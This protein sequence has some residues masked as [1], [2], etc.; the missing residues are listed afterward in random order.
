L[1]LEGTL[2][3]MGLVADIGR[4]QT[5][6]DLLALDAAQIV[7]SGAGLHHG[8]LD[9]RH[10]AVDQLRQRNEVSVLARGRGRGSDEQLV[11][12]L[13]RHIC[14]KG[15]RGGNRRKQFEFPL[16][17]SSSLIVLNSS[18]TRTGSDSTRKECV[19]P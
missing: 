14:G 11:L 1:A 12:G 8:A 7:D 10:L 16:A 4:H 2:A 9:I 13:S 19:L 15:Y 18:G 17:V 6:V 5:H 3:R